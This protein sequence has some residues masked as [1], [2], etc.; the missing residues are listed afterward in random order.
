MIEPPFAAEKV[1]TAANCRK[2]S[3]LRRFLLGGVVLRPYYESC[4]SCLLVRGSLEF[5][6]IIAGVGGYFF[7]RRDVA[8]VVSVGGHALPS[9]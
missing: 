7:T 8:G 1:Q 9:G 5:V 6:F 2:F 3:G 4:S